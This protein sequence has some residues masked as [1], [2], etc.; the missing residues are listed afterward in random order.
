VIEQNTPEPRFT[1]TYCLWHAS[2]IGLCRC[3]S[4]WFN[5]FKTE[6]FVSAYHIDRSASTQRFWFTMTLWQLLALCQ[7]VFFLN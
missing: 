1:S 7:I 5:P 6:L 3:R 2:I 4:L